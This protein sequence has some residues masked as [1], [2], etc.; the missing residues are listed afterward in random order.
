MDDDRDL[1]EA[2]IE[3]EEHLGPLA[4]G[5][6][7]ESESEPSIDEQEPQL[8]E[9]EAEVDE[10]EDLSYWLA[11]YFTRGRY[12]GMV[13]M[14][15]KFPPHWPK[16]RAEKAAQDVQKGDKY[17]I[18]EFPVVVKKSEPPKEPPC[19]PENDDSDWRVSYRVYKNPTTM[20]ARQVQLNFSN[21]FNEEEV[22]AE[23]HKAVANHADYVD[24][25]LMI[26][27]VSTLQSRKD[28]LITALFRE[29]ELYPILQDKD[30]LRKMTASDTPT[31]TDPKRKRGASSESSAS[32]AKRRSLRLHEKEKAP[33][34]KEDAEPV[35]GTSR[36]EPV[37]G[38]SRAE[39]EVQTDAG[40]SG[41]QEQPVSPKASTSTGGKQTPK[42]RF[43]G[44]V[45]PV[46]DFFKIRTLTICYM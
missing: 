34:S 8:D 24:N 25:S 46:N 28:D 9:P 30:W 12:G 18:K 45:F 38:T 19:T 6:E 23:A 44:K 4:A 5:E 10:P 36:A 33:L 20:A 15:V 31:P 7:G 2:F 13:V 35:P 22:I 1:D 40:L 27:K 14:A 16:E 39:A 42:E 43:K 29:E 41:T 3:E 32:A 26:E 21:V 37:P 17:A 11:H